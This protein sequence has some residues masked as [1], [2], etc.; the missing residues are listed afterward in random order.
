VNRRLKSALSISVIGMVSFLSLSPAHAAPTW[1]PVNVT[2]SPFQQTMAD[3]NVVTVTFGP[4]A[5]FW[6]DT[7]APAIY[8]TDASG[9]RTDSTVRFTFSTPV[10]RLKTYYAFAGPGDDLAYSTNLGAVDLT[11]TFASG[12]NLESASGLFVSGQPG[13]TFS[14]GGL[15][16]GGNSSSDN[17]G[18]L[19]LQFS[20]GITYLQVR[21]A[22]SVGINGINLIGLELSIGSAT[23][24]F[25]ANNGQG[26]MADQTESISSALDA[27]TFSR[28]GFSFT[29][30]NTEA[31]GSGTPYS[32]TATF[33]FATNDVLY[34]QWLANSSNE[35]DVSELASTGFSGSVIQFVALLIMLITTGTLLRFVRRPLP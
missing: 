21:G 8:Q 27:N 12:G 33:S 25:D 19:T 17:S 35:P 13:A 23:V 29:G 6:G 16:E 15:L 2:S 11:R 9:G 10:T 34:A 5:G 4:A 7:H 20:T 1:T 31:N 26:T 32:D 30:W 24:T 3:G 28:P 22:P 14:T 18:V